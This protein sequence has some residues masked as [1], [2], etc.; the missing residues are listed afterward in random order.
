MKKQY[1][2]FHASPDC[3]DTS[4]SVLFECVKSVIDTCVSGDVAVDIIHILYLQGQKKIADKT[5]KEMSEQYPEIEIKLDEGPSYKED[6]HQDNFWQV[7]TTFYN[8][9]NAFPFDYQKYDYFL[10][11][12]QYK[13]TINTIAIVH[14]LNYLRINCKIIQQNI[15][16]DNL[17]KSSFSFSPFDLKF[18][19][20]LLAIRKMKMESLSNLDFLRFN[21][22]TKNKLYNGIMNKIEKVALNSTSP[23]LLYG[24]PGVGKTK[25]AKQIYELKRKAGVL[26]GNYVEVNCSTL[27][28]EGLISTL[29]GHTKGA[30]TGAAGARSGLLK[31]AHNGLVFLDE[32]TEIPVSEQAMFLKALEEKRFFPL[33]ADTEVSSNFQIICGTN[34]DIDS[35][36]AKGNFRYDLLARIGLWRFELPPLRERKDDIP[37]NIAY[38]LEQYTLKTTR[39][40]KFLPMA[41]KKYL[42]FALSEDAQWEGNMRSLSASI[43]RM[44]TFSTAGHITI[45]VVED[46]IKELQSFKVNKE[47]R[48][49]DK[50]PILHSL[51]GSKIKDIDLFDK[52]C[53]EGVLAICKKAMSKSEVGRILFASS[54]LHKQ[55]TDDTTRLS[56]YLRS[57]G[58]TWE[59]IRKL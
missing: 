48:T 7:Y 49:N 6:I 4:E 32:V 56:S 30:F 37:S 58:I 26:T 22:Q 41:L 5:A 3:N 8:F 36:V 47:S 46:E 14:T 31:V 23:I 43:E 50:F 38:E 39:A 42:A 21:I 12:P 24:E 54:R 18:A 57:H 45:D 29:F 20:Y 13:G 25:L 53:L 28:G 10:Y 33:G 9:Y 52:F 19:D 55:K 17:D 16:S 1:V 44:A 15:T 40:V 27:K 51:L 11:L 34:K 35:E 59:Q 2:I